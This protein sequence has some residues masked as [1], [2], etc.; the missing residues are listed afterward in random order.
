MSDLE[1]APPGRACS[2]CAGALRPSHQAYVGGG[3]TA[4]VLRC[5][6]CGMQ[7]RGP[8]R[9]AD[10]AAQRNAQAA[11]ERRARRAAQGGAP[12]VAGGRRSRDGT[13]TGGRVQGRRPLDEGAPE[14]PVLDPDTADALRELLGD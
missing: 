10:A 11:D 5:A 7:Y 9:D 4:L 2:R 3:R 12:P 14:N 8:E 13:A 1:P 6:G